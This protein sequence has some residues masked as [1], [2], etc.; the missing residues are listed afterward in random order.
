KPSIVATQMLASMTELP[1]PTR[2]EVSDIASAVIIG[3]DCV[4]LSDE[5]ANGR[6]PIESVKVMKRV[7]VYTEENNPL[8]VTF[9]GTIDKHSRQTAISTAIIN[10]AEHIGA[11]AIVAETQSGATALQI[12]ARRPV[13]SIIAVT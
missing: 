6:Y 7:I 11:K 10:L 12:A 8:R 4:M 2:A 1:E 3:A 13:I 5:T 9:P